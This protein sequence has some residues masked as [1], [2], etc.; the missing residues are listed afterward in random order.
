M[1]HNYMAN[2]YLYG[3]TVQGIQSYIFGTNKLKE[4]IGASEIIENIC[5]SKF[6]DFIKK[7]KIKNGV[8]F[9]QAAGN[10]RFATS[11]EN[12]QTILKKYDLII[13]KYAP[14][15]PFSSAVVEIS[16]INE[17]RYNLDNLLRAERNL[18]YT[19]DPLGVMPRSEH[20]RTGDFAFK[21]IHDKTYKETFLDPASSQKHAHKEAEILTSK[22]ILDDKNVSFPIKFSE[23]TYEG[24]DSWLALIHIDGNGMGDKIRAILENGD[25]SDL[26]A[27]SKAVDSCT[28]EAFNFAI[29]KVFKDR[30]DFKN[31]EDNKK[32]TIYPFRPLV[33]G[34]D[35]V[36]VIMRSDLAI[37]FCLKYLKEFEEL[38]E[39]SDKIENKLTACAGIAFVKEKFPFHY[40]AHLAEELC[41]YAKNESDREYSCLQFHKV[42]D[43]I[44][45][46]YKEILTRE[47]TE[48]FTS[49]PYDLDGIEKIIKNVKN[50]AED[51][52][53][54]NKIREWVDVCFNNPNMK[55]DVKARINNFSGFIE[56]EKETIN[57]LN[58][59]A[60]SKYEN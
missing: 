10:I 60:V 20:R 35:D 3:F 53:P 33:L 21:E 36:T 28:K 6:N 13:Q 39:K 50:L 59:L 14:G 38:T 34:G 43:S 44:I 42:T 30:V 1:K 2:N 46:D 12:A 5:T 54:K 55:E 57:Y 26:T 9:L 7:N 56:N 47:Y 18:T 37:D 29:N 23:L 24:K 48:P 8:S 27:F 17:A 40:S 51:D 16:D 19:T 52:S 4:I 49:G 15:L 45:S 58:L 31:K 22:L 41:V 25:I 32:T 11:K